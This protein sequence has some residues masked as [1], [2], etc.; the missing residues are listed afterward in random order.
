MSFS[1]PPSPPQAESFEVPKYSQI[2][3]VIIILYQQLNLHTDFSTI[4]LFLE[5]R[6]ETML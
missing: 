4:L 6:D 3:F 1:I 2:V 5:R